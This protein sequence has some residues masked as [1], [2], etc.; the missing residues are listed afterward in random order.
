VLSYFQKRL[1][2]RY[3]IDVIAVLSG[4]ITQELEAEAGVGQ[5]NV[6]GVTATKVVPELDEIDSTAATHLPAAVP[7][8]TVKVHMCYICFVFFYVSGL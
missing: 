3:D 4:D 7:A 2:W 1:A 6:E 5:E 8:F